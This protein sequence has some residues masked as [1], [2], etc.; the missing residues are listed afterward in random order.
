[1][2]EKA[3]AASQAKTQF[4][5]NMSHEIR[6]PMNAIIGFSEL[7]L[8]QGQSTEATDFFQLILKSSQELLSII[9][10][11]LDTSK[12]ESGKVKLDI[13]PFSLRELIQDVTK[14]FSVLAQKKSLELLVKMHE[15]P[16]VVLG[17]S[18]RLRQVLLN[19][20]GN[21]IKF[22]ETGEVCLIVKPTHQPDHYHFLV[23]DTGIGM[24]KEQ[25]SRIFEAFTQADTSTTRLYGGTGLGVTLCKQI[26]NLMQSEIEVRSQLG[27]GSDF[28]FTLHLPQPEQITE[29]SRVVSL[30]K[31]VVK[32]EIQIPDFSAHNLLLVEDNPVN[33]ILM[34][35]ILKK[36]GINLII[37]N[38]GAEAVQ[39]VEQESIDCVLMDIQMPVMNG[40]E[41][42]V[43]IRKAHP[44]LPIFALSA[45]Q[46]EGQRQR[47][48]ECGFNGW[49]DKPIDVVKLY[50]TLSRTLQV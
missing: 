50:N 8:Q 31:N 49:L 45:D 12:L 18:T 10:D 47:A 22:T 36:T 7:A 19:L 41:A 42:T 37:A 17:D 34:R 16:N 1:M 13:H 11:V 20:L 48:R 32:P 29:E 4:L 15:L 23:S 35:G 43:E 25:M 9:N 14:L 24:T 40:F 30:K 3:E 2:K 46:V 38:H 5:A 26:L 39:A 44:D 28:N 6:T 21:A 27:V 33:Q